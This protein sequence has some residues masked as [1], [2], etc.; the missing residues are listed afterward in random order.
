VT[1]STVTDHLLNDGIVVTAN[2]RLARSLHQ[3]FCQQQI[4]AGKQVWQ[5]PLI[6]PIDAWLIRLHSELLGA[7]LVDFRLLD[8]EQSLLIWQR[9]LRAEK[10]S[11]V[12]LS[13]LRTATSLAS[14][15]RTLNEYQDEDLPD[16][17]I[18]SADLNL[19]ADLQQA[20]RQELQQLQACD[21]VSLPSRLETLL[22][23]LQQPEVQ[24]SLALDD[25]S[26]EQSAD[27][28]PHLCS[29]LLLCG[30][31]R[32]N[33]SQARLLSVVNRHSAVKVLPPASN[34][35]LPLAEYLSDGSSKTDKSSA[36]LDASKDSASSTQV[37]CKSVDGDAEKFAVARWCRTLLEQATE[38]TP[39][40]STC[41]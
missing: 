38:S 27:G 21:L 22:P 15:W 23:K 9:L 32:L 16:F 29:N 34:Q 14:A 24:G 6:L 28:Y 31:L 17:Q 37:S 5:T 20:Y 40:N 36:E 7:G 8:Q 35:V 30:F 25:E 2:R 13:P 12:F 19:F 4:A 10:S 39:A 26:S 33:Q 1:I 11:A 3:H 41:V 18:G